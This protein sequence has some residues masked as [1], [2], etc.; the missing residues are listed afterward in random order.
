L[1]PPCSFATRA[2]L[3]GNA[4]LPPLNSPRLPFRFWS[5]NDL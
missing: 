4:V 1:T 2:L 5:G 3:V